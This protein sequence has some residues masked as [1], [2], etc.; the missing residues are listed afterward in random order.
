MRLKELKIF[1]EEN[2]DHPKF[3]SKIGWRATYD[4]KLYGD[5][6]YTTPPSEAKLVEVINLFLGQAI[7]V[8]EVLENESS[9]DVVEVVRCKDCVKSECWYADK[10]RCFLWSEEGI[11]VFEDGFC[12]YGE[13]KEQK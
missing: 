4:G 8:I 12:S 3:K 11:A 7:G 13:R 10:R 5:Q 6:L 9:A 2:K 1:V